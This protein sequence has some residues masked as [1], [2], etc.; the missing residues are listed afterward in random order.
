MNRKIVFLAVLILICAL[1]LT[2]CEN[3]F[4]SAVEEYYNN[5]EEEA[6]AAEA[7]P[8]PELTAE[9]FT[10]LEAVHTYY[11]QVTFS[12]TKASLT[13]KYGEPE[14]IEE[15]G[16]EQFAWVMDDGYGF[17]CAF[18]DSGLL[19]AKVVYYEDIRQFG[20]LAAAKNLEMVENLDKNTDFSTCVNLF[21]R[22]I[23]ICQISNSEG[24][25]KEISRVYNWM[26]AQGH[27]VQIL[28]TYEG[29]VSQINY[30]LQ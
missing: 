6:A 30:N 19:R 23:E 11:D 28:F 21:G 10:D 20:G 3:P 2:G 13:Q 17:V 1:T 29:K 8:L 4:Q 14:I 7:T 9:L 27:I 22:P 5:A 26:D 12:D 18:F 16:N 24:T 15:N 25:T